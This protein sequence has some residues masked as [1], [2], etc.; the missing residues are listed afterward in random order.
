[1]TLLLLVIVNHNHKITEVCGKEFLKCK[2]QFLSQVVEQ[3][4]GVVS[5]FYGKRCTHLLCLNQH[6]SLYKKV[7]RGSTTTTTV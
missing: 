1:M 7:L 5:P 4:G 3:H 6:G 2:M